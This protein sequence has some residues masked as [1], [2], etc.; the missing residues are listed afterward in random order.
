MRI[1]FGF[2]AATAAPPPSISAVSP[3]HGPEST[4]TTLTIDGTDFVNGCT[5][6]LNG[7]SCTSVTFV[8]SIQVTCDTPSNMFAGGPYDVTLTNPDTQSDTYPNAYTFDAAEFD[9]SSVGTVLLDL[10][11]RFVTAAGSDVSAMLDQS[12]NGDDAV[13][14]AGPPDGYGAPQLV[15]TDADY[16]DLPTV[17]FIDGTNSA[18]ETP[19]A[20][21]IGTNPFTIVYVGHN[22]SGTSVPYFLNTVGGVSVSIEGVSW[23]FEANGDEFNPGFSSGTPAINV[24]VFNGASSKFYQNDKTATNVNM[25]TAHNVTT[26]WNVGCYRN[27]GDIFSAAGPVA[28]AL[29]FDGAMSQADVETLLDG[30]GAIYGFSIGAP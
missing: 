29:I 7:F 18:L 4:A 11:A 14:P 2:L 5:V 25:T 28:R 21:G 16:N 10:D 22:T 3:S 12:G 8:S 1:P 6:T 17:N 13:T 27:N 20:D 30:L 9:P 26:G 15:A 23:K 24:F 19:G